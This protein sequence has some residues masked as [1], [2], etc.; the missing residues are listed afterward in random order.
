MFFF[1]LLIGFALS[2]VC[3]TYM[4]LNSKSSTELFKN[5]QSNCYL[6]IP[7][8]VTLA[9]IEVSGNGKIIILNGGSLTVTSFSSGFIDNSGSLT[10]KAVTTKSKIQNNFGAFCSLDFNSTQTFGFLSNCGTLIFSESS[11]KQDISVTFKQ[12]YTTTGFIV[13]PRYQLTFELLGTMGADSDFE[14]TSRKYKIKVDQVDSNLIFNQFHNMIYF[15]KTLTS[16]ETVTC[17][18]STTLPMTVLT[19]QQDEGI[20]CPC[21][22]L[23]VSCNLNYGNINTTITPSDGIKINEITGNE[24]T[25]MGNSS[26]VPRVVINSLKATKSHLQYLLLTITTASGTIDTVRGSLSIAAYYGNSLSSLYTESVISSN[27]ASNF[28]FRGRSLVIL[29]S[30]QKPT[31]VTI[32]NVAATI[33]F[34]PIPFGADITLT[35]HSVLDLTRI[36][37]ITNGCDIKGDS[38]ATDAT[39]LLPVLEDPIKDLK[40]DGKPWKVSCDRRMLTLTA[41]MKDSI[42]KCSEC[43]VGDIYNGVHYNCLNYITSGLNYLN[44]TKES[45]SLFDKNKLI[46]NR[47]GLLITQTTNFLELDLMNRPIFYLTSVSEQVYTVKIM[48]LS[49]YNSITLENIVLDLQSITESIKFDTLKLINSVAKYPSLVNDADKKVEIENLD[50]DSKSKVEVPTG[51]TLIV[52]SAHFNISNIEGNIVNPLINTKNYASFV[53]KGIVSVTNPPLTEYYAMIALGENTQVYQGSLPPE[54]KNKCSQRALVYN[55]DA[56]T[57]N[58]SIF[59]V[60]QNKICTVDSTYLKDS[61]D[62]DKDVYLSNPD[63]ACP[64]YNDISGKGGDCLIHLETTSATPVTVMAT[65]DEHR[66]T[67]MEL[68]GN[69]AL[70]LK[71]LVIYST[72]TLNGG[73]VTINSDSNT[74]IAT[75][76]ITKTTTLVLNTSTTIG[77]IIVNDGVEFTLKCY[78]DTFIE[79]S[80]VGAFGLYVGK[81][82]SI[83]GADT[84]VTINLLDVKM[85]A[86]QKSKIYILGGAKLNFSEATVRLEKSLEFKDIS[87]IEAD[88]VDSITYVNKTIEKDPVKIIMS[89]N[90]AASTCTP[91]ALFTVASQTEKKFKTDNSDLGCGGSMWI[92]CPNDPKRTIYLCI[93]F[94]ECVFVDPV[95]T[96][97]SISASESDS[98]VNT[99]DCPCSK[100]TGSVFM[101]GCNTRI[102]GTLSGMTITNITGNFRQLRA[103][104]SVN[105]NIRDITVKELML[106]GKVVISSDQIINNDTF[107]DDTTYSG[108]GSLT[109]TVLN[110]YTKQPT[111][112]TFN[113]TS[114]I[115]RTKSSETASLLILFTKTSYIGLGN[116]GNKPEDDGKVYAYLG[117]ST[118]VTINTEQDSEDLEA[119]FILELASEVAK[120]DLILSGNLPYKIDGDFIARSLVV[121]RGSYNNTINALPFIQLDENHKFTV[122]SFSVIPLELQEYV[123]TYSS[124]IYQVS[125]KNQDKMA[126]S[127]QLDLDHSMLLYRGSADDE[128]RPP[129]MCELT[130]PKTKEQIPTAFV[131]MEGEDNTTTIVSVVQYNETVADNAKIYNRSGCPCNGRYCVTT[132]TAE[133]TALINATTIGSNQINQFIVKNTKPVEVVAETLSTKIMT[134]NGDAPVIFS[135]DTLT[136]GKTF[137]FSADTVNMTFNN[138]KKMSIAPFTINQPQDSNKS[139]HVALYSRSS[140]LSNNFEFSKVDVFD[141]LVVEDAADNERMA[142]FVT[143]SASTNITNLEVSN[144]RLYLQQGKFNILD[145]EVV[146]LIKKLEAFPLMFSTGASVSWPEG[147]I[148]IVVDPSLPKDVPIFIMRVGLGKNFTAENGVKFTVVEGTKATHLKSASFSSYT[149][150]QICSIYVALVPSDFV[151]AGYECPTDPTDAGE[152]NNLEPIIKD[153]VPTWVIVILI[154]IGIFIVIVVILFIVFVV[155]ARKILLRRRNLKVFNDEDNLFFQSAEESTEETKE[156]TKEEAKEESQKSEESSSESSMSLSS[157]SDS[158]SGSGSKSGSQTTSKPQS[159]S[160]KKSETKPESQP[161]NNG[162]ESKTDEESKNKENSNDQDNKSENKQV[163]TVAEPKPENTHELS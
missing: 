85:T 96:N 117:N 21:H 162:A 66:F 161:A 121:S 61:V 131:K 91:L 6:V 86:T 22:L 151:E 50:M 2:Q 33:I 16:H 9:P 123:V 154:I 106:R 149:I 43:E 122:E 90:A 46:V 76:E 78:G 89:G 63:K 82:L 124:D 26:S 39:I 143:S 28:S 25:I 105:L 1:V 156:T 34:G 36:T 15:Q 59:P 146:L 12:I 150:K 115:L 35:N 141:D 113:V 158:K 139:I 93:G 44:V 48:K 148:K 159:K 10:L 136:V 153:D 24:I 132:I 54:I 40:L 47:D 152:Q 137:E 128:T 144:A 23:D 11:A 37:G 111:K 52:G 80:N 120:S 112:L 58:C 110:I 68:T 104:A 3:N 60:L 7:N 101:S 97:E 69:F 88:N 72:L 157:K 134:V 155:I 102:P 81:T 75:I 70:N 62:L 13:N 160:D 55:S 163:E 109:A 53:V 125:V 27:V 114:K 87:V 30:S 79:A 130:V 5:T 56:P 83:R 4:T 57:F 73:D 42:E 65:K 71:V 100:T 107:T 29:A 133:Y 119:K 84:I 77:K 116:I 38:K 64:C 32:D 108:F 118:S 145:N 18:A 127:I 51:Y 95:N 49:N 147:T 142:L 99:R 103:E 67:K 94:T 17:I 45:A 138:T 8:K 19:N 92:I 140:S 129:I 31:I 98:Y 74:K 126:Q 14:I 135:I 41:S 20:I